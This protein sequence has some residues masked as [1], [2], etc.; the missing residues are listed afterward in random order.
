MKKTILP[1]SFFFGVNNAEKYCSLYRNAYD[2]RDMG[3]HIIL[4]GGPGTGKSTLMKKVA[5]RL[6]EKGL[7]VERGYCSADPSS[8]DI[9][10]APEI[11]F[12]ILDGTAPHNIDPIYPGVSER[13]IDLGVAWDTDYLKKHKDE[14]KTL[15]E[16][17]KNLHNKAAAFL[18]VAT[19]ID[20]QNLILASNYIDKEKLHRYILRLKN[21]IIP[22]Q[23]GNSR[24]REHKRF[25]SGVTPEGVVVNYDTVVALSERIITIEDEYGAVSPF[26]AECIG[27]F[28][29]SYGYDVYKCYCP[30]YPRSKV[31]HIIIPQLKTTIFTENSYH[32]SIDDEGKKVHASRFFN[33]EGISSVREKL[34]FGKKA[35]K[36][37]IDEAVRK[38][39][40][41]LDNHNRLEEYYIKATDFERIDIMSKSI[42]SKL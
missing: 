35:K 13:I 31:E 34:I 28:A 42:L 30:L 19:R 1:V 36:E 7:F 14:I 29:L 8:L 6:E 11:N 37:L 15:T 16:E 38:M 9:V 22:E 2:P 18:N 25:L 26:I 5:R 39:S 32:Q 40:L 12:S 17:N 27:E 21:R 10:V 3:N 41:A 33:K 23:G 24:G 20:G 4:K